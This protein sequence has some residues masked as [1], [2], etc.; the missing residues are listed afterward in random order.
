M[1]KA[2]KF[3]KKLLSLL[4][5]VL[6]TISCFTGAVS[7]YAQTSSET[8]YH[9]KDLAYNF[10]AWAET[11]DE[12]SA[13]ALL[14]YLDNV[15]A[16]VALP[17]DIEQNVVVANISIHGKL[18]S[19]NGIFDLIAQIEPLINSYGGLIGGDIKNVKLTQ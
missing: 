12:Q 18:D 16:G 7:A 5:A 1:T 8:K 15:L 3:S 4:L 9:D 19:V 13:T 17:V 14:D 6:M 2:R 11:T 10:L